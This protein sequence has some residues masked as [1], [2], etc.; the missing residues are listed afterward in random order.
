V[1]VVIAGQELEVALADSVIVV[2]SLQGVV[3]LVVVALREEPGNPTPVVR[4]ETP[5]LL[6]TGSTLP[7]GM[8]TIPP[9]DIWKHSSTVLVLNLVSEVTGAGRGAWIE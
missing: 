2:D 9:L 8:D 7:Q 4:E 3:V 5:N 1:V 6:S